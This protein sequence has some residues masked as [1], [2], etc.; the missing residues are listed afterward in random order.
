MPASEARLSAEKMRA[1]LGEVKIGRAIFVLDETTSTNDAILEMAELGA[2]EGVVIFAEHQTAGR[3]QRGNRWEST[4][5]KG[6]W[7]SILLQPNIAVD[8]SARL[9]TWAAENVAQVISGELDLA[10]SVKP[11]N[12]VY[13]AGKKVAGVLAEMRARKDAPHLAIV[14]IGVNANQMLEDFPPGLRASAASLAIL[15][16][17]RVER[18]ALAVALLRQLDRTYRDFSMTV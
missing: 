11:P 9:T 5:G 8:E 18:L 16:G 14:G 6:L 12:D 13:V 3:G 15:R 7:F 17:K 10:A 2:E 1:D 4:P